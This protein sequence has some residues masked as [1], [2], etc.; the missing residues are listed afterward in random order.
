[1]KICSETLDGLTTIRAFEKEDHFQKKNNVL[2]DTNQKAY[3]LN[4]SANCWLA[5]RLEFTG[6]LIVT[7][8]ALLAVIARD[9]HGASSKGLNSDL[10]GEKHKMAMFAGMAGLAI[11]L[12]LSVTQVTIDFD[13][14]FSTTHSY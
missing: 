2:I 4:F 6:S 1:V 11:S 10:E 14:C 8:A 3:F 5:V 13:K 12:S 9:Y 7:M